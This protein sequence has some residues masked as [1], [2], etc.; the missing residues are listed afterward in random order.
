[1]LSGT[2][3]LMIGSDKNVLEAGD[4]VYFDSNLRHAYRSA[5]E[6]A[7]VALMVLAYPERNLSERRMSNLGSVHAGRHA[8]PIT[9]VNGSIKIMKHTGSPT[10]DTIPSAS[11]A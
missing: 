7:C 10:E 6:A 4:S 1:V 5:G 8:T 2:L 3:E 11:G 9:S